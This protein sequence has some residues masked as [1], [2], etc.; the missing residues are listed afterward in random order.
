MILAHLD[1]VLQYL[2]QATP[3]GIER[4]E[5]FREVF[6]NDPSVPIDA[7][8][9]HLEENDKIY[10]VIKIEHGFAVDIPSCYAITVTGMVFFQRASIPGK[11][12]QSAEFEREG[13][14]ENKLV[15]ERTE[16]TEAFLKRNWLM[17]PLITYFLGVLSPINTAFLK[18]KMLPDPK[19]RAPIIIVHDTIYLPSAKP[20]PIPDKKALFLNVPR[21]TKR[22]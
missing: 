2:H 10:L 15:K 3:K 22:Q 16:R 6:A 12:Y 8:L 21:V 20:L 1:Q 11:P 5:L 17:L 13:L 7:I 19:E 4:A 18:Q 14:A 9:L